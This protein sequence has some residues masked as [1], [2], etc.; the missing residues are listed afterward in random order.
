MRV[1]LVTHYYSTHRGGIESVAGQLASLLGREHDIVWAASDCDP[2]PDSLPARVRFLRMRTSNVVERLT[3][4]PLPI[5]GPLSAVQLVRSIRGAD[6]VHLHDFSYLG[7]VLAWLFAKLRRKPVVITQHIGLVP[8]RNRMFRVLL[9]LIHLT[10]GP[11]LLRAA[12][13]VVFIS[14]VVRDHYLGRVTFAVPPLVIENGVDTSLFVPGEKNQREQARVALGLDPARP[15][16]LFV[17]RFV[18]KKGLNILRDLVSRVRDVTWVFAGWGPLDPNSWGEPHVLVLKDRSGRTLV[19]LYHAAD[20]MVLPSV[21]E[22]LPLVIQEAL[23]CGTTVLTG[24]DTAAAVNAPS[25]AVY[26]CDVR[27]DAVEKWE[28]EIRRLVDTRHVRL[29]RRLAIA[30]FARTRWSW[31]VCAAAYSDLFASL[32]TNNG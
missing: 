16:V 18:E 32:K 1:L 17:G 9:Q 12:N 25:D 20:L 23:S 5:W 4:L 3:G 14:R 26:S 24:T 11:I 30:E 22:G 27:P 28:A 8:I 19:P 13:R 6:V 2:S 21:G 10:L 31:D 15:V 29:A 7:N